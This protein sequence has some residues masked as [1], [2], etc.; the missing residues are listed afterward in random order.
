M[1][2][3]YGVGISARIGFKKFYLV[4]GETYF[5]GGVMPNVCNNQHWWKAI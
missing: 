3:Y 5:E 2:K 4:F 1:I